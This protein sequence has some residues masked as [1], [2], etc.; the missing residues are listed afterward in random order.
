MTAHETSFQ[1]INSGKKALIIGSAVIDVIV[2]IPSL[3]KT[4]DDVFAGTQEVIVGGCAYNAGNILKQLNASYDLM[5]P[6]GN[7]SNAAHIKKQLTLDG[8]EQM[9]RDIDGD[10]G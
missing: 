2:T 8:H 7:G 4:G 5:I 1:K 6:V 10:N 9:L 3:P